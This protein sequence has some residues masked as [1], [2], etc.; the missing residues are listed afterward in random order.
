M[1]CG[2][3]QMKL[4]KYL[5]EIDIVVEC[6]EYKGRGEFLFGAKSI[7]DLISNH[8]HFKYNISSSLSTWGLFLVFT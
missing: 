3:L 7:Y 8:F 4:P 1:E 6:K 5:Y 2:G